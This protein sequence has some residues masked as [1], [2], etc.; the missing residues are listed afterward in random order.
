MKKGN[1]I[2]L[3]IVITFTLFLSG[4]QKTP[5]KSSVASKA[6][7]LSG[8][9]IADTLEPGEMRVIDLP[10]H[11]SALEKKSNE[12]V[13]IFVDLDMGKLETGNLPVVEMKN[14]TMTQEELE[15]LVKYF[16]KGEELFV[17]KADTK[18][19]F[20]NLKDR[21]DHKEGVYA[22]PAMGSFLELKSSLNEAIKLAPENPAEDEKAD[23]KFQKKTKDAA[24]EAAN[25]WL[26]KMG[27]EQEQTMDADVFFAAD[28]GKSRLSHIEAECYDPEIANFSRFVWQ[29]GTDLY[30]QGEIQLSVRLNEFTPNTAGY[31]EKFRELLNQYQNALG[32]YTR[33]LE[34]GQR[35]AEKLMDDLGV[36]EMKLLS[37][38]KTLW[39]P[40]DGMPDVRY[41]Q[42]DDFYWQA[43]PEEA[44]AGYKY[45]FTR[46]FGGISAEQSGGGA[47]KETTDTYT[48][49]FPVETVSITVT[50]D[51]AKAFSWTGMSEEKAVVAE[52]VNLMPFDEIQD[53]LFEQIYYYYL[54]KGQPEEDATNFQFKVTSARL[55][56]TYVTAFNKPENAWLVPAWI[57]E[58]MEG[59][60]I[61]EDIKD[62]ASFRVT[63]NAI[64]GGAI[65]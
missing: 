34:D 4:C 31:Q 52:N 35:Q 20:Q 39:F 36:P 7:G 21:I 1:K 44:R 46:A 32:Q 63:I 50:D 23:L 48:S 57:F 64:D 5:D 3:C 61:G 15:K 14:H 8:E 22:N 62:F 9:Y 37:A 17:P 26:Y 6:D 51:G 45:V 59:S 47:D 29:T 19:L 43:D 28:V 53:Q 55:R 24:G 41:G 10:E 18:D 12:R 11:W 25:G 16:A 30:D 42:P 38:D 2:I 40:E 54:G 56:Y 58:V 33:S 60:G 13:T 65:I 49:P 27:L